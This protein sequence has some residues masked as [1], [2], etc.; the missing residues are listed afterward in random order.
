MK[1]GE[2]SLFRNSSTLWSEIKPIEN[3]FIT[4]TLNNNWLIDRLIDWLIDWLTDWLTHWLIDSLTCWQIDE[5][6]AW[7][8]DWTVLCNK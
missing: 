5:M 6:N 3:G 2:W 7:Q 4:L 8:T 1:Q